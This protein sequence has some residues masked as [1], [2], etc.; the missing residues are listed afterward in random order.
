MNEIDERTRRIENRFNEEQNAGHNN[1]NQPDHDNQNDINQN[2]A[3]DR[4]R[5]VPN[6]DQQLRH[7]I[8][9]LTGHQRYKLPNLENADS[10]KIKA[11]IR[12]A[13]LHY[14]NITDDFEDETLM[15]KIKEKVIICT[16]IPERD[17]Q[18]AQSWHQ[19]KALLETRVKREGGP[20]R[21]RAKTRDLHQ[22]ENETMNSYVSRTED[23][24]RDYEALYGPRMQEDFRKEI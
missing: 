3:G 24:L 6:E 2:L 8:Q 12:S 21:L 23:L 9:L 19:I 15:K 7:T 22:T 13:N 18:D 17:I 11:F 1:A 20:D 14:D 10:G 5:R 4:P 16:R